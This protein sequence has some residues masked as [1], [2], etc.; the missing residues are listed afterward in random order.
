MRFTRAHWRRR[1][2]RNLGP[3]RRRG[4][5]AGAMGA[6]ALALVA[7]AC[8]SGSSRSSAGTPVIGGTAVFAEPPSGTPNYIFPFAGSSYFNTF[9]GFDLQNLLYRPLYWF[10]LNGKPNVNSSL[11]LA[12]LPV[13][14]GNEV[15]I[16]LKHYM[17]S[18]GTPVTASDVMFW[19]NMETADPTDF[20]GFTGFPGTVVKDIAVVGPTELT[21][22]MDKPYNRTWFLYNELSQITPM[23]A[24]WDKTASGPSK[25]ATTPSD[26]TA[27]YN[28]LNDQAKDLT[29]Y[30]SSPLWSI[31]DGA[32]K[33]SAFNAD[34]H[35]T[36]V[37]NKS[38]SGPVKP[39]LAEFQ[40]V[41]FT[42]D[43]AEYD[44]LRSPSSS[45]KID[46]GYLPEQDAPPKPANAAAGAN[47]VPGYTLVPWTFWAINYFVVNY[48]STTGNA[49]VIRQLYFRQVLENL[50]NQ[51]AVVQGPLR[52]YGTET[53]GPVPDTPPTAF[54]SPKGRAGSAFPYDP[55]KAKSLLTSHGWTVV[56]NGVST[57]ANPSL[58]GPGIK[59][60]QGMSFTLPYGTG[61]SWIASEMAQLQSNAATVGIKLS[62]EPETFSQV[63]ALAGGNCVVTKAPCDWD[64]ANWGG[65]WS[66]A[67]DYLPTG[68]ELFLSGAVANS[69][70]YSNPADD[71]LISKTLVG[72][73]MQNMYIWQDYLSAQLPVIWQ[74]QADYQLTEIANNL[75]GA[76][77]LNPTLSINPENWYFVK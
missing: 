34:G 77:P 66:F 27:V 15:T 44:V 28:Y 69:G 32:W 5:L 22:V 20:G 25:C 52:G 17:W 9:N 47:P 51:A 56:P 50:M 76:T 21:M 6:V 1:T 33:L 36:F 63:T 40:E 61:L 8:S 4:M 31:V 16:S 23:P 58:C 73:N 13:F 37:P 30:V 38:Y 11:S 43:T 62:L 57:C 55:A 70:G 54:L 12:N 42:T 14:S 59:K 48:Q 53:V 65:G 71:A 29:T 3:G 45:T 2:L 64:M 68:E 46:F 39:K 18:D 24:A 72:N 26:C 49:P 10:G 7:A 75:K 60:G 19:L 41:P 67:P 35:I 74:P